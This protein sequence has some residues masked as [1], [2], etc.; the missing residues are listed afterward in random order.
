MPASEAQLKAIAKYDK[1][2]NQHISFKARIGSR[3]RIKE[4]AEA[5]GQSVNSFIKAAI[6]KAMMEAINKPLEP[7]DDEVAKAILLNIILEEINSMLWNDLGERKRIEAKLRDLVE[8]EPTLYEKF[9]NP[10]L[11]D[12]SPKA[13]KKAL[14][15]LEAKERKE[16]R[17]LIIDCMGEL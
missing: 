5:T 9:I 10:D 13:K 3:D 2:N 1:E 15:K 11:S 17:D 7:T 12:T 4:A 6:S 8:N 14:R 16:I